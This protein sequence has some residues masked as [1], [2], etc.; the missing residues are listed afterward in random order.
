MY[1]SRW[2]VLVLF[3]FA[4]G[5]F[6]FELVLLLLFLVSLLL[7]LLLLLLLCFVLFFGGLFCFAYSLDLI[8][9]VFREK[10][11]PFF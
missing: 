1:V 9:F 3:C 5:L 8:Y 4:L 10:L 7:L 2:V 11:R 6:G